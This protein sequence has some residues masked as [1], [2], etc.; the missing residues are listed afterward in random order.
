MTRTAD[1]PVTYVRT[2]RD[3]LADL[4]LELLGIETANPPGD[5]R[6][7]VDW[8]EHYLDAD[9]IEVSRVAVDP[10]KPNLLV[11]L[12][13]ERD[14]VTRPTGGAR[15]RPAVRP[16]GDGHEGA[17]RSDAVHDHGVHRD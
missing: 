11:R 6:E 3:E 14:E 13:G 7:I 2:H 5:T 12:P 17:A 8:I 9:P 4:T 10:V 16:W 15:R 1:S